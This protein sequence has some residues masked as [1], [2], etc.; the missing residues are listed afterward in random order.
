MPEPLSSLRPD[1]D[2]L[3]G[4]DTSTYRGDGERSET[5]IGVEGKPCSGASE[6]VPTI[7]GY[8][9]EGELGRGGMG[10]VYRARQAGVNRL[11]ALKMILHADYASS[12]ERTR[13]LREAEALGKL[14]HP[15]I[16]HVYE[17]GEWSGDDHSQ[18]VPYFTLEF[19]PG[20]SL[21][22][23]LAGN[24]QP[25][26]ESAI[27]VEKLSRAMHAAHVA[28]IVHR[29]LKQVEARIPTLETTAL[30]V[31]AMAKHRKGRTAAT[32]KE[33]EWALGRL[34]HFM[35]LRRAHTDLEY[36]HYHSPSLLDLE[37]LRRKAQAE[38][39]PRA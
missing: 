32:R 17:F 21:H 1:P 37:L 15:N 7:A 9:L 34:E 24:P 23:K 31:R 20:G 35:Q 33:L 10:V 39:G 26:R 14:R 19:I 28:G 36:N 11:V 18:P 2:A 5:Y 25:P 29:D 3:P 8:A 38:L 27:L 30:L 12:S 16:V 6:I 22:R 4:Q 13:F